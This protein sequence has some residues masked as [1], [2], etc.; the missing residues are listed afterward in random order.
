MR[1][2]YRLMSTTLLIAL[3]ACTAEGP[4]GQ[5]TGGHVWQTQTDALDKVK[6]VDGMLQDTFARNQQALDR[7]EQ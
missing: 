7:Q 5:G 1:K 4:D 2:H 3:T 6:N